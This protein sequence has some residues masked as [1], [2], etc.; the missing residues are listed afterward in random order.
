MFD[1]YLLCE[2]QRFKE[3]SNR[4][5]GRWI[6]WMVRGDKYRRFQK[7]EK[8]RENIITW[9]KSPGRGKCIRYVCTFQI[10]SFLLLKTYSGC[11]IYLHISNV[12]VRIR[13]IVFHFFLLYIIWQKECHN[14]KQKYLCTSSFCCS[15]WNPIR[16]DSLS[17]CVEYPVHR[18]LCYK[19]FWNGKD[20]NGIVIFNMMWNV[21]SQFN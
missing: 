5:N 14:R 16:F 17:Q 7:S 2:L 10:T 4:S 18:C 11:L 1:K 15:V 8:W 6:R 20:F 21:V 19:N 3:W 9:L 12:Q 13:T